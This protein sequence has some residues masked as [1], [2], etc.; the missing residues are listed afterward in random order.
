MPPLLKHGED[1]AQNDR[2]VS[3]SFPQNLES[4][5]HITDA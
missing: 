5:N 2:Y 3:N 4:D 1:P